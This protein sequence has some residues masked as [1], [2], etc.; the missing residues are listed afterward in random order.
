MKIINSMPELVDSIPNLHYMVIGE[1]DDKERLKELASSLGV[2]DRVHFIGYVSD[3]EKADHFRLADVFAMP[4]RGEGFGIVYL[5]ALACGIPVVGSQLDGSQD[6]LLN[7]KLGQLV[8]P[9]DLNSVRSGILKALNQPKGIPQK[10][11]YFSWGEFHKSSSCGI[12]F[13]K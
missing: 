3:A 8:N 13:F 1:G 5:E 12:G 2:G 11:G 4:G 9:E 10:L 7:G 6:A